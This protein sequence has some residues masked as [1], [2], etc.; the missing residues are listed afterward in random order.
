MTDGGRSHYEA[1]EVAP[2]ATPEEIKSAYRRLALV[3]HPDR[4]TGSS[5]RFVKIAR[6]YEVLSDPRRRVTYDR[7]GTPEP[8]PRPARGRSDLEHV[9]ATVEELDALWNDIVEGHRGRSWWQRFRSPR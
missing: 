7:V 9:A 4:P 3:W 2:D 6:A 5:E 1:L 8:P